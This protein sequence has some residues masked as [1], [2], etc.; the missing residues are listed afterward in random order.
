MQSGENERLYGLF[1]RPSHIR[2]HTS[3]FTAKAP[4]LSDHALVVVGS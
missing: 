4:L 3:R 1:L 2:D